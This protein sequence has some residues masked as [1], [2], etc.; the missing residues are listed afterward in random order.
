MM[1]SEAPPLMPIFRSRAQGEVLALLLSEP[2][3]A[4]TISEIAEAT[5]APL[6]SAQSEVARLQRGDL[7]HTCKVGRTRVVRVNEAN[8]VIEPLTRVVMLTFG[9][10]PVIAQEFAGLG[11][12]HVLIFGSWAAR[13]AGE[14]GP[15][16]A[17]IDVLVVGDDVVRSDVCAAAERADARI[18]HPVN[19][20]MR[21][22]A[23]SAESAQDPLLD[24]I[25]RRPRLDVT[26][27]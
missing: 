5:G 3:R 22:G 14:G 19:P 23:A 18:G 8:P 21:S 24:E 2:G 27:R 15:A 7:V 16:P 25:V 6:T 13:L 12:D 9:A 4:W 20:V 26:V 10:K 11:A 1:R 17:D